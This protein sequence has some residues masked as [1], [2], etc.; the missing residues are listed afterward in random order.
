MTSRSCEHEM[1]RNPCTVVEPR[2]GGGAEPSFHR[3]AESSGACCATPVEMVDR[4]T[5]GALILR[6]RNR[7]D[8]NERRVGKDQDRSRELFDELME[9][10]ADRREESIVLDPRFASYALSDRLAACA[11]DR[12]DRDPEGAVELLSLALAVSARLEAA[13]WS[14]G[15][16]EDLE[17]RCWALLGAAWCDGG[18]E[19][20][21]RTAFRLARTHL[22][23]GTGDPLEEAE[24]LL[25]E[26]KLSER[27]DP[28]AAQRHLDRAGALFLEHGAHQRLGESLARKGV[29]RAAVGDHEA[30]VALLREAL[31]LLED[32]PSPRRRAE[33]VHLLARS[34]LAAGHPEAAWTEIARARSW[35]RI[36][37][38]PL[39]E[40]RL[41]AL[42]GRVAL[43]DG[44]TDQAVALLSAARD[45]LLRLG[46][47]EEAARIHL[48]VA[49]L[50]VGGR[51]HR[52]QAPPPGPERLT[53][54]TERLLAAGGLSRETTMALLMVD[55]AADRGT[56]SDDLV[57]ALDDFL[58]RS[59]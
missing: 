29:V 58:E 53:H 59:A 32:S 45:A 24:V 37:P 47:N 21:A 30:A 43:A 10:P 17:A 23:Q 33:L 38:D 27:D 41:Q 8:E 39:V 54:D 5:Y 20:A 19:Q 9:L 4:S 52:A 42:E 2:G 7:L 55:R 14:R 44:L 40:A 15:L 36:E 18:A 3:N 12:T 31:P 6:I 56:L 22:R 50:P 51:L 11:E 35:L 57:R 49:G 16:V 1:D 28:D 34:L 25:L 46:H 48:V 26:A 13:R